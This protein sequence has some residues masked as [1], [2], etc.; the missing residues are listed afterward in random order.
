[1][2]IGYSWA[3]S[4]AG[5]LSSKQPAAL[6]GSTWADDIKNKKSM[7]VPL[8]RPIRGPEG[9]VLITCCARM[10]GQSASP[11]ILSMIDHRL[12]A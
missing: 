10:P 6:T 7:Q 5:P 11:A 8:T 1:M 9:N 4:P 2:Q 12:L 3:V